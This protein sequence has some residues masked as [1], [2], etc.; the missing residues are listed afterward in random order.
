MALPVVVREMEALALG[1]S[2]GGREGVRRAVELGVRVGR[3]GVN[4]MGGDVLGVCVGVA[5]GGVDETLG[6]R[7]PL[8]LR[9]SRM[10]VGVRV[11]LVLPLALGQGLELKDGGRVREARLEGLVRALRL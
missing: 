3:A 9:V 4:V 1:E 6:L 5:M 7:E 10:A 11:E 2:V 8:A